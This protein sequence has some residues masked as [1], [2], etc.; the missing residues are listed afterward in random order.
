MLG[1]SLSKMLLIYG[2]VLFVLGLLNGLAVQRFK[3]P[4]MGL[5]A[6]LAAMQNGMVLWAFGLIWPHAALGSQ[7]QQWIAFAA[8]A[9]LYA[10]WLALLLAA[11]LGTSRSTPIAGAGHAA[12]APQE[13]L[14]SALLVSG[15]VAIILATLG[16][17][18]G[19]L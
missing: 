19:L 13:H 7:A 10:I 6:H 8:V 3:N 14:V 17:L 12:P 15:S 1:S 4:R 5:S 2:T 9:A 11:I 18:W 16:L